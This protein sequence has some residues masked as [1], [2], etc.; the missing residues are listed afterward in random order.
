[1]LF[2][3]FSFHTHTH[4]YTRARRLGLW[5]EKAVAESRRV[6][7]GEIRRRRRRRRRKEKGI[8]FLVE[9][10]AGRIPLVLQT[11]RH[12]FMYTA[13]FRRQ[14]TRVAFHQSTVFTTSQRVR[15]KITGK[16]NGNDE[17]H[18]RCS[19]CSHTTHR[20]V[21]FVKQHHT[22]TFCRQMIDR[23]MAADA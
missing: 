21:C 20:T 4:L 15:R 19:R 6:C 13:A 9:S 23:V 3:P 11:V 7:E 18:G 5:L 14:L 17:E 1:M 8:G 2:A 12:T 16:V 22:H 10:E